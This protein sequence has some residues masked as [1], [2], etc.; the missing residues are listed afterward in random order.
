MSWNF[1]FCIFE[2]DAMWGATLRFG[3]L[4]RPVMMAHQKMRV[5]CNMPGLL[6]T[7]N[8]YVRAGRILG[9]LVRPDQFGVCR[10][11]AFMPDTIS[12]YD[13]T[14][15]PFFFCENRGPVIH[16]SDSAAHHGCG[17]WRSAVCPTFC[18]T[19]GGCIHAER[20]PFSRPRTAP[21]TRQPAES[22]KV[23]KGERGE[24]GGEDSETT[25]RVV[26]IDRG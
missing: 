23:R 4:L 19:S 13:T 2:L 7:S 10:Q 20:G 15:R 5:G 18:G 25:A 24:E 6:I 9:T 3:L 14:V 12:I 17:E 26:E 21:F 16:S 11:G 1:L 22:E 8:R